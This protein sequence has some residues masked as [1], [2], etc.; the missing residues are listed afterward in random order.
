MDRNVHDMQIRKSQ[1]KY[2]L[3]W[4]ILALKE[5]TDKLFRDVTKN[6]P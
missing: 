6:N 1:N 4:N 2:T 5:G 3:F